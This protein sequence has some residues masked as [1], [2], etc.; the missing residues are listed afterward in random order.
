ML[1]EEVKNLQV[2]TFSVGSKFQLINPGESIGNICV[3]NSDSDIYGRRRITLK[4][5][6]VDSRILVGK[7]STGTLSVSFSKNYASVSYKLLFR[8]SKTTTP[9]ERQLC[10]PLH[11]R[12]LAKTEAIDSLWRE[13]QIKRSSSKIHSVPSRSDNRTTAMK[14]FDVPNKNHLTAVDFHGGYDVSIRCRAKQEQHNFDWNSTYRSVVLH[15][16]GSISDEVCRQWSCLRG[17]RNYEFTE[18]RNGSIL[19]S[20]SSGR[21][22]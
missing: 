21:G 18:T 17:P 11:I 3:F 12:R 5:F 22:R 14:H 10:N 9:A 13:R 6:P 7:L 4:R 20:L 1:V 16:H 15:K 19:E 8:G 2:D